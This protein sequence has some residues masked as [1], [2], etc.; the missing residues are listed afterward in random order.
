MAD[1]KQLQLAAQYGSA[2][3][4]SFHHYSPTGSIA[5][6]NGVNRGLWWI[7]DI[8]TGWAISN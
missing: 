7:D 8:P 1:V 4:H 5:G 3:S 6:I 2:V